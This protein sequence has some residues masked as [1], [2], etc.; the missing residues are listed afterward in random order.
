M[1]PDGL[2]ARL[3]IARRRD[4]APFQD[5]HK[6]LC[7]RLLPHLKRAIQIH[8]RL[9]RTESERDLYA[10]AVDQLAVATV[11]LDERARV[12]TTNGV[13]ADILRRAD[14]LL[15]RDD[16]LQAVDRSANTRLTELIDASIASQRAGTPG[17]ARALNSG[18]SFGPFSIVQ[19]LEIPVL[20]LTLG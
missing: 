20:R 13:A 19:C 16:Q 5:C 11:I 4:E 14:G 9:N 8:A 1:E 6:Q 10:G 18:W 15:T 12:L 3:R 2:L 17:T 7:Q